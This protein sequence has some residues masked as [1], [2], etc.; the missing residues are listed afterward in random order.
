VKDAPSAALIQD[1]ETITGTIDGHELVG[2]RVEVHVPVQ[3]LASAAAFWAG[4]SDNRI[5]VVLRRDAHGARERQ[6]GL[7]PSHHISPV[8]DGQQVAVSGSIQRVP[9]KAEEISSWQLTDT[10]TRELAQRDIYIRADSVR[11]SGH[12]H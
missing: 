9:R 8:Q 5:L 3:R 11:P 4:P 1:I 12:G 2:R 6:Q 7:P 10:E